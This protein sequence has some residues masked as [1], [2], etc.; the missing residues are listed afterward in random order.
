MYRDETYVTHWRVFV[1]KVS[2]YI[3]YTVIHIGQKFILFIYLLAS[4]AWEAGRKMSSEQKTNENLIVTKRNHQPSIFLI[5][6]GH[7]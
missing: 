6:F 7:M 1:C 2:L 3:V 4:M 5:A